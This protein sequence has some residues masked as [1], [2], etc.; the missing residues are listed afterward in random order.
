MIQNCCPAG[1]HVIFIGPDI[2]VPDITPQV[3]SLRER[4]DAGNR[5]RAVILAANDP[6]AFS[7]GVSREECSVDPAASLEMG[8]C[9]IKDLYGL[10]AKSSIP[11][12][13]LLSGFC[14]G[15]GLEI[16]LHPRCVRFALTDRTFLA[17][18]EFKLGVLPGWN[19]AHNALLHAGYAALGEVWD[20][21]VLGA[22]MST[23]DAHS[24]GLV[25][26]LVPGSPADPCAIQNAACAIDRWISGHP[27]RCALKLEVDP[28][29]S[30]DLPSASLLS[31]GAQELMAR[32]RSNCGA[33]EKV[34]SRGGEELCCEE[35]MLCFRRLLNSGNLEEALTKKVSGLL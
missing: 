33:L 15:G 8:W 23:G 5:P 16:A 28:D 10:A 27:G 11:V 7:K 1:T 34:A 14:V 26:F 21:I 30:I 12:I 20:W 19:G 6:R 3:Q 9:L 24:A 13:A 25:D 4:I 2:R 32:W 22:L 17:L 35:F 18:P 31:M 29:R